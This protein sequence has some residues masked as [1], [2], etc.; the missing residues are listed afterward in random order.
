MIFVTLYPVKNKGVTKSENFFSKKIIF[1][2]EESLNASKC[3]LFHCQ[4]NPK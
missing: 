4:T 2:P 1:F 3:Y